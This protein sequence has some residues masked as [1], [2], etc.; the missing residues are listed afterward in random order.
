MRTERFFGDPMK[1]I[2]IFQR[3]FRVGGIQ[4]ALINILENLDYSRYTVDV[5]VFD[6]KPFYTL[7]PRDGL[8]VINCRPWPYGSRFVRFDLARRLFP[9]I[10]AAGEYD[11]AVDFNSYSAECAAGALSVKAK[12]RVMWIH[13]DMRIKYAE[14]PRYR[15]LW[16]FFKGKFRHFDAFAAVSGGIVAGF[17]DM[18][19]LRDVPVTVV[20]NYIDTAEI[21]RKAEETPEIEVD[22]SRYNLCSMGRLVH[23][24]GFDLLMEDFAKV[25]AARP[26]MFLTLIGD[27]PE[28]QSLEEQIKS[29]QLS[30]CVR[31]TGNL[32]NPFPLLKQMDGFALESRYEGQGI[33][34][35]EAKALGL[36][37]FMHRRLEPYNPALRGV[38]DMV[39]ALIAA[40]KQ[41]KHRDDLR[42]Y[43]EQVSLA[44]DQVFSEKD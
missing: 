42:D 16:H 37:L 19:G 14:E 8:R 44:L 21:F 28:R 4:K 41:E 35:W 7:S 17:R 25:H 18:T 11:A 23:Q 32:R 26:D 13:N 5:Y 20:P 1:R 24:K 31:M 10:S 15:L 40:R 38:E 2:A 3:D 43:N 36:E 33:V 22:E 27:G 29:L 30:D 39:S 12:K 34:L 9:G 6:D